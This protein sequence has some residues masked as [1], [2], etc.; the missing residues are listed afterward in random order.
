[1][2][3]DQ[4]EAER[5]SQA[6][7]PAAER[8]AAA[9]ETVAAPGEFRN[10]YR[11]QLLALSRRIRLLGP[12]AEELRERRRPPGEE[13]ERAL[14]T[15][16]DALEKALELLKLGREGSRISLVFDR[17]RVMNIFQEVVAQLE[18]ALLDFPYNELDISDE[19]REQVELVHAQLKRAK[20][21]VDMPDDEF[22]NDLISLYNK[23]YD[24]SAELAILERLSE[25][26]HLMTITDLTQESLALHEMVASG[27][28]QD[29]GEHIEK[30]SMLLKKIKDFV[31]TNNPEMGPPMASKIMDTSG[32]QKSVIVPDEFRCPIS[33]ELMK[34][35]VIVAT[36]Q[37]YERSCI[38]KW[39]A[40][41]HHTCP[42]TQ[43]RMANTTLT[44]NYVLRSLISQWCETN[45]IEAPKR[46][47]QPNKPMP[48]CSSSE[49]ANIDA[50]LSK[51]CSPDPEEQRSAAAELRLLAKRNAHNRLC[52][53]EAGAI[54]LLL[55]LLSSS[56]LR[57]QEHA[58][59][60]LLNLSIHEDNKASIMSSGAVPSVVHVL[61]NGSMEA[62]ENAAATLF[63]LSVVDE[64]KVMIGGTGAIP[65]LVVL[66]SEGSQRGKK[67][68]AAAL[69]NLCIYQGNK[70]RAIRA[71]LV[72]LIMGLVTNPTGAL[73]DE[74][75]AILS[76]LSSHQEG[77][78][79]IGAAEPV[80]ALVELLGSGSPRNR[81]NA[82]AV[83]L[84]LCSGEQQLVHLARAHECGIMV[85]LRELALNG[86]ERGKR[87]AVQ[88]LER[89]SRFVVQQQEEQ[90][91]N[92]RL[93][94]TV[95]Q[96]FPQAP[97]QV[98]E[99]EIPDQL[100]S[101]A[102]QYPTLL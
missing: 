6:P 30:L 77:K 29:P 58:V 95:A 71:G 90:E 20:E 98:Q 44:A 37:T 102:S 13:E 96:V 28:G 61:K 42:T 39:L 47:S 31:Q 40:S 78:A 38:E 33:L 51:L 85:P 5:E 35:P 27:G 63:S 48:A 75:M 55:S 62:R 59:T 14:A 69:F 11:R 22:Y 60:A 36:G 18:Q 76:I 101:P 83:M 72:P 19:V 9:V 46:S 45:G 86:T 7:A 74:A 41:G 67:D 50:L 94:A 70:G 56:D 97:E 2:A 93:Q 43:Q 64:Y 26:L 32:D 53:A 34:D 80:P 16:A 87:K 65:A 79:A 25:K 66:L 100:E 52:I 81:E 3:G 82:A 17:D 84:H 91:S 23:T 68:A 88:L 15:L 99:R 12:F 21:R 73:M 57:T 1:M 92:S 10:A 24:P 8:V 54:P 4:E 49:R 89:M